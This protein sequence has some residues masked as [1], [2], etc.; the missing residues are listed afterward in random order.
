[1]ALLT[2]ISIFGFA[3]FGA[4]TYVTLSQVKVNGALYT[5]IIRG[6]DAYSEILPCTLF[7]MEP[8]MLIAELLSEKVEAQRQKLIQGLKESRKVV[9]DRRAY[10]L[11]E[12][13]E[14][15]FKAGMLVGVYAPAEEYLNI[16]ETQFLPAILSGDKKRAAEIFTNQLKPKYEEHHRL[17]METTKLATD[18]N[19]QM[20]Q[21]AAGI[22]QSRAVKMAQNTNE[23]VSRLGDNSQE[24][25]KVIRVVT[26]IA[27]Q[28]NLLA[29]N[30]AIE[31]ARAGEAS[32]GFAVV[33]NEVKELAKETAKATEEI[34]QKVTSIQTS[35]SSAVDAIEQINTIINQISDFQNTIASAVE[36]Q[37]VT[38]NETGR[39]VA[40]ASRG[41]SEIANNILA[42]AQAA[43]FTTT[44][45]TD[46]QAAAEALAKMAADLQRLVE[47]FKYDHAETSQSLTRRETGLAP[48]LSRQ[49]HVNPKLLTEA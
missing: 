44:S 27:E 19:G 41:S 11:K 12:L 10:W 28:T 14:S 16:A 23:L 43:Q 31:A 21:N 18:F 20:E 15:N 36:E 48:R 29:L 46:S 33:A 49:S 6:K 22:I 32:K 9:G 5:D 40:E 1:L 38:T 3:V 26:S 8:H 35:T 24:I 34:R 25:G 4:L 45:A 17:I 2:G 37:T 47:K 42:V 13:P 30:A 39:N 7:I